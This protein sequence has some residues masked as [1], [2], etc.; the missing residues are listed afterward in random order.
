MGKLR[1]AYS[2]LV[3][4]SELKP[5]LERPSHKSEDNIKMDGKAVVYE[6]VDWI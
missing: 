3:R 4:K 2:I 5:P 6:G 1:T